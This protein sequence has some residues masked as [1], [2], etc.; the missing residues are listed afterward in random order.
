MGTII[1]IIGFS[2]AAF[3]ASCTLP[4]I[5]RALKRHSTADI[6]LLFILLSLGG[7]LCSATYIFYTNYVSGYWQIPQYFNYSIAT[8]LV[9]TLLVIKLKYDGDE[10][11]KS[12]KSRMNALLK[13]KHKVRSYF[14][15]RESRFREFCKSFKEIMVFSIIIALFTYFFYSLIIGL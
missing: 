12:L 8:S 5:I 14:G 7:N 10:I 13:R 11:W 15:D 1:N 4:Q 2:G 3:F 6:S 9:I